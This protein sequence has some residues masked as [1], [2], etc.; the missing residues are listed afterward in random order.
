MVLR[1][2]SGQESRVCTPMVRKEATE[3]AFTR[4]NLILLRRKWAGS[5][6]TP[7]L[8]S[9]TE[10]AI[11]VLSL[12]T[13]HVK[14]CFMEPVTSTIALAKAAAE[15]SKKLYELGKNIKDRDLKHQIDEINERVRELKQ[16]AS[17]LE[18]QNRE[19]REQL[20]FNSDAYEFRTPFWYDKTHP[21]RPLC[22]KWFA[23]K[24]AAPM[25]EPGQDCNPIYRRC[26]VCEDSIRVAERVG[27]IPYH[28]RRLPRRPGSTNW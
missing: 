10:P 7:G 25:S 1:G 9:F 15:V 21:D 14:F 26:L 22:P 5:F 19:L 28:E 17:E 4:R 20:R 6:A 16:S 3:G 11:A 18:D 12:K 23:K 27:E 13:H 24:I 2:A 8:F